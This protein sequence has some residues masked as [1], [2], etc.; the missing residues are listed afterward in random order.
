MISASRAKETKTVKVFFGGLVALVVIVAV[1]RIFLSPEM[2]G[3]ALLAF[4]VTVFLPVPQMYQFF[5][6]G[7]MVSK[8]GRTLES[9]AGNKFE[10]ACYFAIHMAITLGYF[11]M[12]LTGKA[13][14]GE[15][16][17]F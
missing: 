14:L 16:K 10:R 5:T 11:Y 7:N 15:A 1:V 13:L 17:V 12:L 6:D 2:W 3:K 8:L 4:G 9:N